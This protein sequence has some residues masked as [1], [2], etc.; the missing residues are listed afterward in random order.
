MA[1]KKS[2]PADTPVESNSALD[3]E[4]AFSSLQ[5]AIGLLERGG[6]T[7]EAA[8]TTFE[9][10][11]SLANRCAEILD[12]AELRITRVLESSSIELDEP[13]F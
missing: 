6:L 5:E 11:M 9:S 3:F 8:I 4:Q 13:A 7:L 2:T 1:A 10:G 12:A